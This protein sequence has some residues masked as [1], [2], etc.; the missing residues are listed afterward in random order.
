VT[1]ERHAARTGIMGGTFDPIHL[2]HLDAAVAARAALGL[3]EVWLMPARLPPHRMAEPRASVYHRLAMVR[4]AADLHAGLVA[5]DLEVNAPGPSYTSATL[6]RL[7]GMGWQPWQI[8]FITGADAFVEIATWRDYPGLLD[9]AHFVV[10][11]RP[12]VAVSALASRLPALAPRLIAPGAGAEAA[13]ARSGSTAVFLIDAPTADV[14]STDIRARAAT[15]RPLAGM[16]PAAVE[17]YIRQHGLYGPSST[18]D[19]LHDDQA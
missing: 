11:S 7:A 15:G 8:F 13:R 18:A 4:L 9:R 19:D 10:V 5:S 1:A 3:D 16:V 6:D 12:G 2:G 14:S 17:H